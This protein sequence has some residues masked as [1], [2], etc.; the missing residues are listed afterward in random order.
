MAANCVGIIF[1]AEVVI[2][3]RIADTM[4]DIRRLAAVRSWMGLSM[5]LPNSR[6][7]EPDD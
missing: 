3:E 7:G 4:F 5:D 1:H 2:G 6:H